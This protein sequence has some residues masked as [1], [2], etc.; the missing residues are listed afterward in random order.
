[1]K[2]DAVAICDRIQNM[3]RSQTV[4]TVVADISALTR[5]ILRGF[6][7]SAQRCR[8]AATLG[9]QTIESS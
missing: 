1:M 6:P 7:Q 2:K 8:A 4:V 3:K 5:R 9:M